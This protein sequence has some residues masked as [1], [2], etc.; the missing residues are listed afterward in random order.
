M[1]LWIIACGC[2]ILAGSGTVL[3][4]VLAPALLRPGSAERKD[5]KFQHEN[6]RTAGLQADALMCVSAFLVAALQLLLLNAPFAAMVLTRGPKV[7]FM[8]FIPSIF[9]TFR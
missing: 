7:R 6:E 8:T 2:C 4:P 9:V 1:P 5:P 3:L